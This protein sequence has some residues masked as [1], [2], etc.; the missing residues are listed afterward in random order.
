MFGFFAVRFL[1]GGLGHI[2]LCGDVWAVGPS[3]KLCKARF[4]RI[5]DLRAWFSMGALKMKCEWPLSRH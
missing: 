1:D 3:A 5:A 2:R 4:L